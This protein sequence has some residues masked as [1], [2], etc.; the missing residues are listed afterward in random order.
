[1]RGIFFNYKNVKTFIFD[2]DGTVW[3][4]NSLFPHMAETI[5][6]LKAKNRKVYYVSD[7]NILSRKGLADKLTQMGIPTNEKEII[8]APYAAARY[9]GEK[10]IKSVYAIGEKG[11]IDELSNF[12]ITI[13]E[14]SDIVLT[15]IDRGFTFWKLKTAC[16]LIRNGA[17]LYSTGSASL[18]RVNGDILP[19]ELPIQKAIE[20]VTGQA[21]TLLGKPSDYLKKIVLEEFF[22]FPEDTLFIGDDIK[23]DVPFAQKCGFRSAIVLHGLTTQKMALEAQGT[24]RPDAIIQNI[25]ELVNLI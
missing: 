19:A 12:N 16:D 24:E 22:L 23:T 11:L 3:N 9:L 17:K 5:N 15:S 21:A 6:K 4:W 13:S 2:L 20:T 10:K 7:N 25:R 1:M 14:K 18:W 8:T